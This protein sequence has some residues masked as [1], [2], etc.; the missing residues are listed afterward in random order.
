MGKPSE[1]ALRAA[2][3]APELVS[4]GEPAPATGTIV[5]MAQALKERIGVLQILDG[6]APEWPGIQ[7]CM[8]SLVDLAQETSQQLHASGESREK[9]VAAV[10]A[11]EVEVLQ[12]QGQLAESADA[13]AAAEQEASHTAHEQRELTQRLDTCKQSMEQQQ[14]KCE[15]QVGCARVSP[16]PAAH[17]HLQR[18][19]PPLCSRSHHSN[20][21]SILSLQPLPSCTSHTSHFY[22]SQ[23]TGPCASICS[24]PEQSDS[25]AMQC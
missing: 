25:L 24:R 21:R 19:H 2:L 5:T 1:K 20:S 7:A 13:L 3:L 11:K 23:V 22:R 4:N 17:Q 12:L 16:H 9:A 14:A 8:E 10:H 6:T 15:R 18:V